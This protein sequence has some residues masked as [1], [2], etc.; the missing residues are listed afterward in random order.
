VRDEKFT[1]RILDEFFAFFDRG[2]AEFGH[3]ENERSYFYLH[4]G[5][6]QL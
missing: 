1:C 5:I 3:K 2:V 4:L 6:C